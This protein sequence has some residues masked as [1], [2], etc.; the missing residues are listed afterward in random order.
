MCP[1]GSYHPLIHRKLQF[2]QSK[3]AIEGR[4]SSYSTRD[5]DVQM[6]V[7]VERMVYGGQI[8]P[9]LL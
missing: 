1:Q 6:N 4:R 8:T 3:N 9:I 7:V 5:S 2:L